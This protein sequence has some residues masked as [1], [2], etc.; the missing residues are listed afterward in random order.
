M[1]LDYV[2]LFKPYTGDGHTLERTLGWLEKEA[3]TQRVDEDTLALALLEIFTEVANGKEYPLDK[4]PCGC[5]INKAGTAITHA[6]RERMLAIAC[7][8]KTETA[9]IINDRHNVAILGHI[10]R[11][12]EQFL[13]DNLKP[14]RLFDWKKSPI[15]RVIKK[16][17]NGLVRRSNDRLVSDTDTDS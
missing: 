17:K 15:V 2:E 13:A 6:I 3:E 16:V 11:Q 9:R 14:K 7:N 4:C 12:N 10:H 8:I 1:L 5:G